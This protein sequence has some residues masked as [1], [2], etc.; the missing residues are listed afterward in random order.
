[1][2]PPPSAAEIWSLLHQED[3]HNDTQ[4]GDGLSSAYVLSHVLSHWSAPCQWFTRGLD[5]C[6]V[7]SSKLVCRYECF[8][9]D[10]SDQLFENDGPTDWLD[11]KS[12]YLKEAREQFDPSENPPDLWATWRAEAQPAPALPA[13][14]VLVEKALSIVQEHIASTQKEML[15]QALADVKAT[16]SRQAK[17]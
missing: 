6:E 12:K 4:G 9:L 10:A 14:A 5:V 2:P 15:N 16:P 3:L 7:G 8:V 17:I 11:I 13:K 1:M